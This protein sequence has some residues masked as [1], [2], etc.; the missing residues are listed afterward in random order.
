MKAFGF[1]RT[2]AKC[3]VVRAGFGKKIKVKIFVKTKK[4][5]RTINFD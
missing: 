3:R 1:D 2:Y 4:R 5:D